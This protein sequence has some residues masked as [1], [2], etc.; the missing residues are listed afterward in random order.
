VEKATGT[1]SR[2]YVEL[3]PESEK[4]KEL[5]SHEGEEFI[6]VNEGQVEVTYGNETHD[7]AGSR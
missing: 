5:S 4:A 3:L 1:W 6:V 2:F 7:R